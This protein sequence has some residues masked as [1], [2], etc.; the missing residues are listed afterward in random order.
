MTHRMTLDA[1][2]LKQS[3]NANQEKRKQD[4]KFLNKL[5]NKRKNKLIWQIIVQKDNKFKYFYK[6]LKMI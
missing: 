2:E 4:L 3:E 1:R 5:F 6:L